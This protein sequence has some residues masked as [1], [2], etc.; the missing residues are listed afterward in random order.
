MTECLTSLHFPGGPVVKNLPFNAGDASL[1][2]GQGTKIP[3]SAGQLSPLHN[4]RGHKSQRKIS[5]STTKTQCSQINK[6][7]NYLIPYKKYTQTEMNLRL[8]FLIWDTKWYCIVVT[9]LNVYNSPMTFV[10]YACMASGSR[11]K[12]DLLPH[13]KKLFVYLSPLLN[14]ELLKSRS[15]LFLVFLSPGISTMRST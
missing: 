3:H 7:L 10:V 15:F 12:T 2:P 5:C 1:I 14:Y 11:T 6:F 9:L 8:M 4:K 13:I